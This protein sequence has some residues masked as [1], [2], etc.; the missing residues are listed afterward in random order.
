M[1]ITHESLSALKWIA[2]DLAVKAP[3]SAGLF[4]AL[5]KE[6][7]DNG[8]VTRLV[9]HHPDAQQP[10][11]YVKM[12]AA[13]GY[14]YESGLSPDLIRCLEDLKHRDDPDAIAHAWELC[15]HALSAHPAVVLATINR[16]VQQQ[17]PRL[18]GFLLQGVGMLGAPRVRL[19]EL[20]ACGGLNLLFDQYWWFGTGWT[21][22]SPDSPVRLPAPGPEPQPFEIVERAGCDLAPRDPRNPEDVR[23][24]RS[25]LAYD[26]DVDRMEFDDAVSLAATTP[27]QIDQ[28][29]AVTWLR[30]QLESSA[31]RSVTTVVWHS[32]FW[33]FLDD[34]VQAEIDSVLDRAARRTR[35]ACL[36]FDIL[37]PK[38]IPK[39]AITV[40]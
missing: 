13:I 25:F 28:E 20:G 32:L 23:I 4:S 26:W 2:K 11:F 30:H 27:V 9:P 12:F 18:A 29:D 33:Q 8:P 24:M 19:L 21:W 22:G 34:E 31:S 36:S 3:Q 15:R 7:E 38:T 5:V 14:L 35:I 6:V 17:R 10:Y 16:P 39:L 37:R 1:T 40:Y